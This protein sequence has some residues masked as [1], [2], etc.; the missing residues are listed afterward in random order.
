MHI[1]EAYQI[2][3]A[4]SSNDANMKIREGWKLLT[5]VVTTHPNGNL[6]PCY[7]LAKGQ[8]DDEKS[9]AD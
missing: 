8:P 6:H 4:L 7:I 9:A 3:E 5:V 2:M 1:S